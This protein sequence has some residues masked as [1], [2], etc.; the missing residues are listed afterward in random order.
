[1]INDMHNAA[2][3]IGAS[4]VSTG[5]IVTKQAA[6]FAGGLS[7][8]AEE[9]WGLGLGPFMTLICLALCTV[10]IY[11]WRTARTDSKEHHAQR[12]KDQAQLMEL[13]VK[14][15]EVGTKSNDLLA[16]LTIEIR[17]LADKTG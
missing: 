7:A 8:P 16:G 6:E 12:D 3:T 17:R 2:L 14:Q 15:S 5:G 9:I 10:V 13:V 1:M 11:L 4:V